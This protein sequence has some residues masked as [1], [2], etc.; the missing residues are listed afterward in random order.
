MSFLL[1]TVPAVQ[2]RNKPFANAEYALDLSK[3]KSV[4]FPKRNVYEN[5]KNSWQGRECFTEN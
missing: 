1:I 4:K 2:K 5:V 3:K